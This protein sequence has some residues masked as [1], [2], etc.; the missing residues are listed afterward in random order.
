MSITLGTDG[1]CEDSDV[2]ALTQ[3]TFTTTT[4]PTTAEVEGFI[5]DAFYEID[6]ALE[7][8]GYSTP[9]STSYP[10]ASRILK[11]VNKLGASAMAEQARRSPAGSG[12]NSVSDKA[13]SWKKEFKDLVKQLQSGKLSLIDAPAGDSAKTD[14]DSTIQSE[15]RL[16]SNGE[17]VEPLIEMDTKF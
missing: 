4:N 2:Q 1:Y 9:I 7:A 16:D 11:N 10:K 14:A 8:G 6:S 12:M 13:E 3:Q 5:T 15:S 17:E